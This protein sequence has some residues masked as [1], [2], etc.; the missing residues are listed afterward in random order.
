MMEQRVNSLKLKEGRFRSD[1]RGKSVIQRQRGTGTAQ[2]CGC[3]IAGG[4][5]CHGW[6]LGLL[7]C[8]AANPQQGEGLGAVRS[9]PTQACSDSA[10]KRR[11]EDTTYLVLILHLH[12]VLG[13]W[14]YLCDFLPQE[15]AQASHEC[16]CCLIYGWRGSQLLLSVT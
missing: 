6:A 13:P 8:R 3:P 9:L 4:A 16:I 10:V 5:H 11:A 15:E 1:V 7:S 12:A 2:S 14:L